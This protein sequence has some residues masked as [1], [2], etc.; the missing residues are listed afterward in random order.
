M[1]YV[2][3]TPP[4]ESHLLSPAECADDLNRTLESYYTSEGRNWS[5]QK[6]T[7]SPFLNEG[8][9]DVPY[10]RGAIYFASL[11]SQL[12]AKSHGRRDLKTALHPLFVARRDGNDLDQG[13]FETMLRRELGPVAVI[14]FHEEVIDGTKKIVPP[15]NAFGP[16]LMRVRATLPSYKGGRSVN[17][18]AWHPIGKGA[19]ALCNIPY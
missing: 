8:V 6:I 2:T 11:N 7:D 5:Q 19:P 10:G 18:Y 1:V 14:E 17:G 15:S 16:C 9:R 12:L 13:D 3:A 4:C